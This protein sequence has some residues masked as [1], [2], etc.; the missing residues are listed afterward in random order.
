MFQLQKEW[1]R[2]HVC[3]K[4]VDSCCDYVIISWVSLQGVEWIQQAAAVWLCGDI[5]SCFCGHLLFTGRWFLWWQNQMFFEGD[6]WIIQPFLWWQENHHNPNHHV[7]LPWPFLYLN[8]TRAEAQSCDERTE[9]PKHHSSAGESPAG[10]DAAHHLHDWESNRQP[11]Q[12]PVSRKNIRCDPLR[13]RL[14]TPD[15]TS[16]ASALMTNSSRDIL[17]H[18][19]LLLVI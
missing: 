3:T 15:L 12:C 8:Q 14:N 2:E 13:R 7:F 1:K 11:K 4:C 17:L 10:Y 5:S 9:Q 18:R 16:P 19:V 6:L